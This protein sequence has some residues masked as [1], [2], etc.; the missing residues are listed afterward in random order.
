MTDDER[1]RKAADLVGIDL[2]DFVREIAA[3]DPYGAMDRCIFCND[4]KP[5]HRGDCK[6]ILIGG[7]T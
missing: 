2:N 6:W 5:S 3:T 1:A 4:P 7:G